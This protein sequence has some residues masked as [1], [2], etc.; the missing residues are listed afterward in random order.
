M[1]QHRFTEEQIIKLLQDDKKGEQPT[2]ELCRAVGC[3]PASY[4]LWKQ[5]YGDATVDEARRRL[6]Q[7]SAVDHAWPLRRLERENERLLKLV[8]QQR[9]ELE[10]MK[11]I[12]AKK[13]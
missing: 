4:Y 12:L 10:G 11:E 2:L 6:D 7:S 9:L 8:G 1:K 5:K 13:H 3:S